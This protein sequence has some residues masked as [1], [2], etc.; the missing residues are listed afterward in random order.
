MNGLRPLMFDHRYGNSF[1]HMDI[2]YF[3]DK[4][5]EELSDF[6]CSLSLCIFHPIT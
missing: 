6:V 3:Y 2:Q 1:I 5:N 4:K